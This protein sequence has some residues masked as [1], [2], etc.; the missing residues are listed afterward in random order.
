VA[1]TRC[2]AVH[3]DAVLANA[4][5]N[6]RRAA[7]GAVLAFGAAARHFDAPEVAG[8][9]GSPG[10]VDSARASSAIGGTFARS[11][12]ALVARTLG[13]PAIATLLRRAPVPV[14]IAGLHGGV[15]RAP[16]RAGRAAVDALRS[17]R[18]AALARAARSRCHRAVGALPSGPHRV[19]IRRGDPVLA[20]RVAALEGAAVATVGV[21]GANVALVVR[22]VAQRGHRAHLDLGLGARPFA[23]SERRAGAVVRHCLPVPRQVTPAEHAA[24]ARIGVRAAALVALV[25]GSVADRAN[26]LGQL[27]RLRARSERRSR[28]G[29]SGRRPLPRRVAR[30][31][32]AAHARVLSGKALVALLVRRIAVRRAGARLHRVPSVPVGVAL[33]KLVRGHAHRA[34]AATERPGRTEWGAEVV[35]AGLLDAGEGACLGA[36]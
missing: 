11:R 18:V 4:R 17:L 35:G 15:L 9:F 21:R 2:P 14:F 34:G 27:A 22:L 12:L 23:G 28:A 26:L 6:A 31:Q 30:T 29:G 16:S 5:L 20:G 32:H 3:P 19:A 1:A 13:A 36:A 7:P 25:V 24:R 33:L 8:R 10:A